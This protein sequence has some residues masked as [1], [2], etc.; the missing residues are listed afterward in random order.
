MLSVGPFSASVIVVLVALAAAYGAGALA[1]RRRAPG[2]MRQLAGLIMDMTLV[3][4][5]AA[6]LGFVL[7]WWSRYMDSPWSILYISDGGFLIWAGALAS[8]AF[9]AWRVRKLP[10]LKGPVGV[11][12]LTGWLVWIVAGGMLSLVQRTQ[13]GMPDATLARLEGSTVKLAQVSDEPMVV[14]LWATWCPPCRREMPMLAAAQQRHPGVTF[15]FVNQRQGRAAIRDYLDDQ[16]LQLNHVLIDAHGAIAQ[17]VGSGALPTTLF[18]DADGNLVGTH[19]G[20]LTAASLAARLQQFDLPASAGET[21]KQS[22][23]TSDA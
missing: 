21:P 3:G 12:I 4:F 18:Y 20:M 5:L 8:A 7:I 13:I 2:T 23:P 15:V 19:V 9:A 22:E 17:K 11:A 10:A 14:N 1:C 6:R 16:N